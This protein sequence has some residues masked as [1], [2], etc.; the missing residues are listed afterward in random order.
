MKR[1][2]FTQKLISSLESQSQRQDHRAMTD[3]VMQKIA[4]RRH[5]RANRV[6]VGLALAAALGS[7]SIIPGLSS[8]STS[9]E[10]LATIK[11]SPQLADDLDM[12]MVLGEAHTHGS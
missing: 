8:H 3:Q 7:L 1:D 6:G 5:Q 12:L 11:I 9:P 2:K 4:Q 10:Q